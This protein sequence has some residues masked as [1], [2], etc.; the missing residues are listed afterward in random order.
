[1]RTAK[2]NASVCSLQARMPFQSDY[3]KAAIRELAAE[4]EIDYVALT[5]T[6][7]AQDVSDLRGFLDSSGLQHTA[8]MAK[9]GGPERKVHGAVLCGGMHPAELCIIFLGLGPAALVMS[10]GCWGVQPHFLQTPSPAGQ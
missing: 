6:C 1:M 3:D 9:V 7:S 10:Q 2:A 4:F 8:I 5:Y